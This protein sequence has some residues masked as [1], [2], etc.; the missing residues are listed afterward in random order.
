MSVRIP[1]NAGF[2]SQLEIGAIACLQK[3]EEKWDP[4]VIIDCDNHILT[5]IMPHIAI[6][7]SGAAL[8]GED[9]TTQLATFNIARDCGC[10]DECECD[11]DPDAEMLAAYGSSFRSAEK[12]YEYHLIELEI[13][14]DFTLQYIPDISII[15][16]ESL[17]GVVQRPKNMS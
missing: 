15:P 1:L 8:F 13:A 14:D 3:G 2:S 17:E 11:F 12:D 10:E 16:L 9:R 5:V 4:F 7:A 6:D